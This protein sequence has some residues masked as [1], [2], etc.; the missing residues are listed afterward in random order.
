MVK[1]IFISYRRSDSSG[2]T[3][4]LFDTLKQVYGEDQLFLDVESIPAGAA[5]DE[6]ITEKF[7]DTAIVLVVI[8][9]SWAT[10]AA[11]G[12]P[13]LFDEKDLVRIEVQNALERNVGVIPILVEDAK[14]PSEAELPSAIAGIVKRNAFRLSH[15][16]FR[17]D[18]TLLIQSINSATTEIKPIR[19]VPDKP[20]AI[21]LMFLAL[22]SFIATS[23]FFI[24]DRFL[25]VEL[26]WLI[27]I[28]SGSAIAVSL[29]AVLWRRNTL[30]GLSI[31]SV[32]L[33]LL[34][35]SIHLMRIIMPMHVFSFAASDW[36]S[37]AEAD[38]R[39]L[40]VCSLG[41]LALGG[42][43]LAYRWSRLG[44]F[45]L[46]AYWSGVSF[47]FTKIQA[48]S[49]HLSLIGKSASGSDFLAH[50]VSRHAIKKFNSGV[51]SEPVYFSC[52]F[53]IMA[54]AYV[55]YR[56]WS[57]QHLSRRIEFTYALLSLVVSFVAATLYLPLAM[58][59]VIAGS[60]FTVGVALFNSRARIAIDT[61]TLSTIG[62]TVAILKPSM[63]IGLWQFTFMNQGMLVWCCVAVT[64]ATLVAISFLRSYRRNK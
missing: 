60:L 33:V 24:P 47:A 57:Y 4:R 58:E 35:C 32:W 18:V 28:F 61:V 17:N 30:S 13:R 26:V 59:I 15:D 34:F 25:T 29:L 54:L 48:S 38:P 40:L 52:Y 7:D 53:A 49:T 9:P 64:I 12:I 19:E 6:Y 37:V 27:F 41:L 45:E 20:R 51:D 5:F 55:V 22:L 2:V 21:S 3:G 36:V 62:M 31:A 56:Y 11:N 43:I 14:V 42:L 63:E 10:V 1:R 46:S 8:G 39:S 50:G 44:K 23:G 16:R